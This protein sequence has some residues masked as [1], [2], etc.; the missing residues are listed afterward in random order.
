[1]TCGMPFVGDHAGDVGLKTAEGNV[2]T[3]DVENGAIKSPEHIFEGG[4]AY[5]LDAVCEGDRVLAERLTRKNMKSLPY[6]QA[7]PFALLDG[8]VATDEEFG[9]CMAKL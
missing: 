4:V 3:F 5:F 8:E 7:H 9:A 2:C 6:W 1:M